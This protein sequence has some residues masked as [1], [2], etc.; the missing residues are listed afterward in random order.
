MW[1]SV[2]SEG[3][4]NTA[5]TYLSGTEVSS[6]IGFL[7]KWKFSEGDL[8]GYYTQ[9]DSDH[10]ASSGYTVKDA[11][12]P[13]TG[14]LTLVID[15]V[16]IEF[17]YKIRDPNMNNTVREKK[18]TCRWYDLLMAVPQHTIVDVAAG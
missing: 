1:V 9:T 18:I 17:H 15:P 10:P 5:G 3:K 8:I 2:D 12:N 11:R 13:G 4:K 14:H 16:T 6:N 7:G